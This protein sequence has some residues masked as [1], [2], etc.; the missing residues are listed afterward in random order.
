VQLLV[1]CQELVVHFEESNLC[2]LY[3]KC[4]TVMPKD[5]QLARCIGEE[6]A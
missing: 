6:G 2:A 5:I 1:L 3:A 4:A